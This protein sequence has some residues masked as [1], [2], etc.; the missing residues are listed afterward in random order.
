MFGFFKRKKQHDQPRDEREEKHSLPP[1]A[2]SETPESVA[3]EP[4]A[5]EP[6][7]LTPEATEAATPEPVETE[8]EN[9]A[10]RE[11]SQARESEPEP[12]VEPEIADAAEPEPVPA[13]QEKPATEKRGWFARIRSGLGKTRANLTEGIAGLFLG[14][15]QID[16]EL[17]EDLETQL[18]MADVGIEA[19]T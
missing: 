16:D 13:L 9:A 3:P 6:E 1:E 12:E 8:E 7:T 4:T 18:L 19:T 14:K 2:E 17:I 15:K 11:Q 10:L 5:T